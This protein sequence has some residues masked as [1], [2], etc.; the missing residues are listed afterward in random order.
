MAWL[1]TWAK[2]RKITIPDAS[3]EATD[4]LPIAIHLGTAVGIG[5][6]D[7]TDIFDDLGANYKKIALTLS[8]GDTETVVEVERWD[9]GNEKATL[10][11]RVLV[12]NGADTELYL[13]WDATE[14]DNANIKDAGDGTAIWPTGT[15][16]EYQVVYLMGDAAGDIVDSTDNSWDSLSESITTYRQDGIGGRGYALDFESAVPDFIE[17]GDLALE[18]ND[19][20]VI[21]VAN[22]EAVTASGTLVGLWPTVDVFLLYAKDQVPDRWRAMIYDNAP[23][24]Y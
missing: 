15:D 21:C 2:R 17:I 10:W 12:T 22:A 3:V 14:G 16:E 1:G 6:T 20:T 23:I 4:T 19:L 24:L 5:S 8:D 18:D 13:Y 11:A 7:V 9:N